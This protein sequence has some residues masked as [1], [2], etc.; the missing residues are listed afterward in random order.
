MAIY[1][2]DV[3]K[4]YLLTSLGNASSGLIRIYI[5]DENEDQIGSE[6]VVAFGSPSGG[7]MSM[8]SSEI[9]FTIPFSTTVSGMVLAF[10]SGSMTTGMTEIFDSEYLF[11]EGGSFSIKSITLTVV[12]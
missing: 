3:T 10:Y 5:F 2:A 9:I 4:N 11:Y 7:V 12:D 1:T 6:Q 8:S